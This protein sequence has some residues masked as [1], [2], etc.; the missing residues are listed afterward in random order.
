[1]KTL[2]ARQGG[3]SRVAAIFFGKT[4]IEIRTPY[5]LLK[6]ETQR[7]TVLALGMRPKKDPAPAP[8]KPEVPDTVVEAITRMTDAVLL[9]GAAQVHGHFVG[10]V[11]NQYCLACHIAAVQSL[12]RCYYKNLAVHHLIQT[13]TRV[14]FTIAL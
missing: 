11:L 10:C 3:T 4:T 13:P 1:M 8:G 7:F 12:P 9:T 2:P 5:G 6:A 14:L